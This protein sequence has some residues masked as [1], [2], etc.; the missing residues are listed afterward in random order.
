MLALANLCMAG[1][2]LQRH[3]QQTQSQE[4]ATAEIITLFESQGVSL[5]QEQVLWDEALKTLELTQDLS[6]CQSIAQSLLDDSD[7]TY[8]IQDDGTLFYQTDAGTVSFT[9]DGTME[10]YGVL[11]DGTVL[12]YI[13]AFCQTYGYDTLAVI[14]SDSTGT[15]TA[16]VTYRGI[17][18]SN[19]SLQFTLE[20]GQLISVV[21][22]VLPQTHSATGDSAQVTCLTALSGFLATR[23][24]TGAVVSTVTDVTACYG[25]SSSA[26]APMALLPQ[27]RIDTDNGTY[28]VDATTGDVRYG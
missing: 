21:G 3:V 28:L 13:Q 7:A 24:S 25:F 26:T 12:E 15:V 19:I 9:A 22:T 18:V 20:E 27:W 8:T 1:V 10:A 23:R 14:L 17:L 6:L 16:D 11:G 5:T 4:R 2:L